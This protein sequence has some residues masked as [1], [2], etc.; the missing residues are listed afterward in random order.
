MEIV[1]VWACVF[2]QTHIHACIHTQLC[3]IVL[4][5]YIFRGFS[6]NW[7]FPLHAYPARYENGAEKFP[8]AGH[9]NYQKYKGKKEPQTF[10][11]LSLPELNTNPKQSHHRNAQIHPADISVLPCISPSLLLP[12]FS[13]RHQLW[14]LTKKGY[15]RLPTSRIVRCQVRNASLET[16]LR[17][18]PGQQ[19]SEHRRSDRAERGG[20]RLEGTQRSHP[21][22]PPIPT[23][24]HPSGLLRNNCCFLLSNLPFLTEPSSLSDWKLF[25]ERSA[26]DFF[27]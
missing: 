23:Q 21:A 6:S 13:V 20:Q 5:P 16:G 14:C 11:I 8:L 22:L 4:F 10:A 15:G 3:K 27:Y 18:Q 2:T 19:G 7:A 1:P 26:P 9:A 25:C 24:L 12:R 17:F